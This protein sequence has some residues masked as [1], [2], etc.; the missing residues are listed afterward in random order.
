M[1]IKTLGSGSTSLSRCADGSYVLGGCT[2]NDGKFN[3]LIIKTDIDGEMQWNRTFSA[4]GGASIV[5]GGVVQTTDGGYAFAGRLTDL[6]T[7]S[8]FW[9]VKMDANGS[10]LWNRTI[11]NPNWEETPSLI[12]TRDGGFAL[13]GFSGSPMITWGDFWLVK[14]DALGNVQWNKTYGTGHVAIPLCLVQASDGAY[15]MA[16]QAPLMGNPWLW[17]VKTDREQGLA[18]TDFSPERIT[19]YGD[20]TVWWDLVRVQICKARR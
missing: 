10:P 20:E 6:S 17:L 15:V 9:L 18:W 7:Q 19:I 16:G 3:A 1:W 11:E 5:G 2:I 4:D 8:D 13:V 14:T 12:E